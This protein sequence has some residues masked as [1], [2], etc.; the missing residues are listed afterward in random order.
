M[1]RHIGDEHRDLDDVLE[2]T[3]PSPVRD[4]SSEI[5]P[6]IIRRMRE[7]QRDEWL[8]TPVPNLG[9]KSPRAAARDPAMRE[10]LVELFK[11]LEYI[12]ERKRKNGEPYLDVADLRRKLGLPPGGS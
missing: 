7:A 6:A 10:Q 4:I 9:G 2:S 8:N 3:E 1:L 12:E 5:D 11:A